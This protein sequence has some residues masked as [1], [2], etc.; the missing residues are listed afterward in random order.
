MKISLLGRCRMKWMEVIENYIGLGSVN[1][2]RDALNMNI[3]IKIGLGEERRTRTY[4][5]LRG[6]L[7]EHT[8][9]CCSF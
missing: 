9:K 7:D 4:I 8:S 5:F 6:H 2:N 1:A 3:W